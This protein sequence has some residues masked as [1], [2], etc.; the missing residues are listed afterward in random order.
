M[1]LSLR[2][3]AVLETMSM[4]SNHLGL[5]IHVPFCATKCPYCDFYSGSYSKELAISYG[6]AIV[7]NLEYYSRYNIKADTLY[8]GGG[9]P[10][11]MPEDVI[12][13]VIQSTKDY[14]G[15]SESSEITLEANPRTLNAKKLETL[16]NIG[17]NRLSIGVQSCVD[18]E[19]TLLGRNHTFKDC[20]SIVDISRKCGFENISCD[21]MIGT[22]TQTMDS[23]K[24]SAETLAQL[25]I[26]HISSYMLKVEDNTPYSKNQDILSKLPDND[27]VAEMYLKSIE[28]FKSYGFYQYEISNFAKVGYESKHNLKYWQCMDYLGIGSASHSCFNGKRFCVSA[29]RDK[30]VSME[31]QEV[32]VTEENPYTFEEVAM[33]SLRLCSG[34]DMSK[35]PQEKDR[36]LNKAKPLEKFGYLTINNDIISLTPNGFLISNSII[37]K[38]IL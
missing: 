38:L 3:N 34:L 15:I 31:H 4:I 13:E 36:V 8:F 6:K 16:R 1:V 25:D 30:F 18:S 37:E 28:T 23:L 19:L 33:L 32:E 20:K 12:G 24:Y 11:L 21:L 7:R 5:Y 27:M 22:A 29:D 9:T 10:S 14:F 2:L 26:Q 35:Y 17:V